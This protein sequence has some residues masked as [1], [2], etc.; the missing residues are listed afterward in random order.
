[1]LAYL[2]RPILVDDLLYGPDNALLA[3]VYDAEL[4]PYLSL[5]GF[6]LAA[7]SGG[8]HDSDI[9]LQY[10]TPSL[11]TFD[12][13]LRSLARKLSAG[14]L[15]AHIRA[16]YYDES[17]VLNVH[18]VHPFR[19]RDTS[20]VLGMNG[21]LPRFAEMR[22]DLVDHMRSDIARQIEGTTD[23]EWIYALLLSQ[24]SDPAAPTASELEAATEAALRILRE[25]RARHGIDTESNLNLVVADG[26]TIVATRF[27]YD[28]GWYPDAETYF[29]KHRRYDFTSLWCTGGRDY[30]RSDGEWI[31][32]EGDHLESVI[33][34][35]EPI[36][37]DPSS[38][39]A[40]PEY[41]MLTAS[42]RD[43]T[44]EITTREL[45]L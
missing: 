43:G 37:K 45:D 16:V 4:Y 10:R 17:Q 29:S 12:R 42:L 9:P 28:Y 31:M 24:L 34:A 36:T 19:F 35:S 40:V 18:N 21:E 8:F 20:V 38:W 3:Q 26:R 23:S 7:W 27:A 15:V 41:A 1:M 22:Y 44:V 2:G 6:G 30:V 39:M 13:N 5:G 14:A 25:L 33:V 32:R 11:P